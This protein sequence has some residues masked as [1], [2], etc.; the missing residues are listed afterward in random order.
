MQNNALLYKDVKKILFYKL[1]EQKL[2]TGIFW[3]KQL[4]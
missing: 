1:I 4:I 3:K 2:R